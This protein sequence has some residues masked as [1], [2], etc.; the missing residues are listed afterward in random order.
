MNLKTPTLMKMFGPGKLFE[1]S[2]RVYSLFRPRKSYSRN[3]IYEVYIC[4]EDYD[5][6]PELSH[7]GLIYLALPLI[8]MGL[9]SWISSH[10]YVSKARN[11]GKHIH[12][13]VSVDLGNYGFPFDS[14]C[15]RRIPYSWTAALTRNGIS[16]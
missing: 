13:C 3:N 10:G 11:T 6:G 15:S 7:N 5:R 12:E 2:F 1:I 9:Y 14:I 4:P 8:S 16:I